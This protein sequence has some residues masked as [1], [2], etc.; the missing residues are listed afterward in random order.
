LHHYGVYISLI[1]IS[2]KRK[3]YVIDVLELKEIKP[4]MKI[5]ENP[6]IQKIFHDVDYDFRMLNMVGCKPKNIF[7]TQTAAILLGKEHIGLGALLEEYFKVQKISK[8]QKADWTK[9]PLTK[10]MLDYAIGD[11]K[12]LIELRDILKKELGPRLKWAEEDFKEFEKKEWVYTLPTYK[13]I[14]GFRDLSETQRA[15]AKRLYQLREKLAKKVDR[16]VHFVLNNKKIIEFSISNPTWNKVSG[17]HPI[18]RKNYKEFVEE[19]KLGRKEKITLPEFSKKKFDTKQ[20]EK[21]A[22][23]GGIQDKLGKELKMPRHLIMNKDQMIEIVISGTL[24]S[25]KHWQKELVKPHLKDVLE[26][27]S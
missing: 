19:V 7:D 5:L 6:E 27:N 3:D 17:V 8:F 23:L 10:E 21:F 4:L 11:T 15:I 16:P 1:Q 25:L 13:D 18:V 24:K 9:R 12:Y 20:K 2:S 22:L 26:K 14:K